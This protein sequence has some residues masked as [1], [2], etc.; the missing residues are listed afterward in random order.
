MTPRKIVLLVFMSL[1]LISFGVGLY[2]DLNFS[3]HSPTQP[4]PEEGKVYQHV[5]NKTTVYLTKRQL[6]VSYIPVY[7]FILSFGALAYLG[8]RWKLIKLASRQPKP[9]L[10]KAENEDDPRNHTN[11]HEA[12]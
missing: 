3:Q 12:R 6:I 7:G 8:V 10:P 4:R 5:A 1:A 11:R 9:Q 2:V